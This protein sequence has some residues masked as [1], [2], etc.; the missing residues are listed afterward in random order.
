MVEP[1]ACGWIAE[2]G[3]NPAE[4][5]LAAATTD[6]FELRLTGLKASSGDQLLALEDHGVPE[7]GMLDS[8]KALLAENPNLEAVSFFLRNGIRENAASR[9]AFAYVGGFSDADGPD[10]VPALVASSFALTGAALRDVRSGPGP[11]CWRRERSSTASCLLRR[12]SG[13]I[14]FRANSPCGTTSATPCGTRSVPSTGTVAMPAGWRGTPPSQVVRS[15]TWPVGTSAARISSS[16]AAIEMWPR[17]ARSP[18]WGWWA[19]P[20]GGWG[21]LR[22]RVTQPTSSEPPTPSPPERLRGADHT[23]VRRIADT[24]ASASPALMCRPIGR[25]SDSSASRSANGSGSYWPAYGACRCG[26]MG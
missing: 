5:H 6:D 8:L 2:P 3:Q 1:D 10:P 17:R 4:Q 12:T 26:G 15:C 24:I 25:D 23:A 21:V 13:L 14:G 9:A 16:E 11:D 18:C 7:P 19:S 22:D 20:A